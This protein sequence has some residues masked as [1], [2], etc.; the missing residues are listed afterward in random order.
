MRGDLHVHST[1]SDG[2]LSPQALVARALD[3]G[4]DV[5]AIADHDSV[6]GI[7]AAFESAR[8]TSLTIVPAVELSTACDGRDIHLLGYFIDHRSPVL[9]EYLQALRASRLQRAEKI[10]GKLSQA[11]YRIDIDEVLELAHG[12]SVGRSHIAHALVA[13][14]Q[15]REF[16]EA[17][18]KLIGRGQPFF[19]A[20][21]VSGPEIVIPVILGAGG[22][23]V[24]AHP[25][26]GEHAPV[27]DRLV[28]AGLGGVE[29][30]H[31]DHS[32]EQRARYATIASGHGLLR[33]GG[34]DFHGDAMPN[35]D[36]GSVDLPSAELEALLAW[37]ST[38]NR[39]RGTT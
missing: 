2:T 23:A 5:L 8:G 17:F 15:V 3:R 9:L 20:R 4:L 30:Y 28:A 12:G 38:H 27:L 10:V 13:S 1:A 39:G 7:D 32:P 19:M 11:G 6:E 26:I 34:S 18:T 29:A 37:G 36:M 21:E 35:P 16:S 25:G 14:G 24:I 31:S 33:T 22:L